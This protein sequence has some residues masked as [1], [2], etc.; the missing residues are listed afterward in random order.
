MGNFNKK[1]IA[2]I[3]CFIVISVLSNRNFAQNKNFKVPLSIK[4]YAGVDRN[5]EPVTS[6][7]PLPENANITDVNTL[8]IQI[9]EN[10]PLLVSSFNDI[11]GNVDLWQVKDATT[12]PSQ[13][14]VLS[15]WNGTPDDESK[16]IKWLLVDARVDVMANDN[17]IY[18]LTNDKNNFEKS[19][20]IQVTENDHYITVN[21]GKI[22]A[23]INK[24]NFNLFDQVKLGQNTVLSSSTENGIVVTNGDGTKYFTALEKPS[25][26]KIEEHGPTK[27]VIKVKGAFKS[28]N[29][30][31]LGP[32]HDSGAYHR[33]SQNYPYIQYTVRFHFYDDK[34]YVRVFFTFENNGAYSNWPENKF[35]PR[36]WLYFDDLSLNL[37]FENFASSKELTSEDYSV[38]VSNQLLSLFQDHKNN[39]SDESKNFFYDI[40]LD[41]TKVRSGQRSAGWLDMNNGTQGV[42]VA[43][44][45]FWQNFPK[46]IEFQGNRLSLGLWP[47]EGKFPENVATTGHEPSNATQD[48][49][50]FEGGRHKTYELLF[51]FY[52]GPKD[53]SNTKDIIQSFNN[54]LFMHAPPEW[55]SYTKAL[56]MIAPAN[57]T[58][59]NP[60]INE[61]IQRYER[62]QR[63]KVYTEDADPGPS[64]PPTSI[65][66]E[67]EQRI[68]MN[69][70]YYGWFHFGDL[71]WGNDN[72]CS[73]HYDWPYS[74]LLHYIRTGKSKFFE[75]GEEMA[76]HRYDI[77]QYHGDRS[78]SQGEHVWNNFLQRY[79]KSSHG[80]LKYYPY[81][82]DTPKLSHTWNGGLVLYY[83]LT[84][85]KLAL[86]AAEE[87]GRS[88]FNNYSNFINEQGGIY[89]IRHQGWALLNLLN[90]YRVNGEKSYLTLAKA[91]GKNSLLYLEK[92]T[93]SLGY[94]GGSYS[95][96]DPSY[97]SLVMF[98]Y[99]IEPLIYLH[100]YTQD[101]EIMNLLIRMANWLKNE[102]LF[103]GYTQQGRYMPLQTPDTW[104]RGERK[105]GE[106]VRLW[107]LADLMAYVYHKTGKQEYL[108]LARQ[109]FRDSVFWLQ[110]AGESLYDP[111]SRSS[112]SYILSQYPN[113]ETKIHGWT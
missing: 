67:R 95:G 17:V 31:L 68:R 87:V 23:R 77:D 81:G 113:S 55:Y 37:R 80:N 75:M 57:M 43:V 98:G 32:K 65:Y 40:N 50:Q 30:A 74:M 1:L 53:L 91:I 84:G 102:C 103:G 93:G 63:A 2:S 70:D 34:D 24:L 27:V 6:G 51:R 105:G 44:R 20:G 96:P 59:I 15:R 58:H 88:A 39:S 78:D 61:A 10:F 45:H 90:L 25:E 33:F 60:D 112:I 21:T 46:K 38:S 47:K 5:N 110:G 62:I 36:Q 64:R 94:W 107:F 9:S 28:Q 16:P 89:E 3:L 29:G 52:S 26:V 101:I 86:E 85:D 76:R 42:T 18:Y 19:A 100:Y 13:F 73:L 79:E 99:V 83:L 69:M 12:V 109:M 49:Y 92:Q 66:T 48:T 35:A 97:Q 7:I 11:S 108:D 14:T 82:E 54:P 41:Y 56:G 111:N 72:Y 22:E 71:A 106:I 4:E 104:Y 8:Q